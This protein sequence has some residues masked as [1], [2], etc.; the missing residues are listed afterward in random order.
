MIQPRSIKRPAKLTPV[1]AADIAYNGSVIY[2]C[3]NGSKWCTVMHMVALTKAEIK[4]HESEI[5]AEND[6]V[7]ADL[8]S[9]AK[10]GYIFVEG[11]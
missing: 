3:P 1:K 7:L 11:K 9:M 6:K 5:K 8:R 10:H 4:K 2:I